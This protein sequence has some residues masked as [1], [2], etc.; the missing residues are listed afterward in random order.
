M[1]TEWRKTPSHQGGFVLDAG[2]HQIAGIRSLIGPDALST[3]IAYTSQIKPH[4]KPL[5]TVNAIFRTRGGATGSLSLSMGL[6]APGSSYTFSYEEGTVVL[7]DDLKKVTITKG[8]E[9][10]EREFDNST[11]GMFEEVQ[12]WGEGLVKGE[13]DPLQGTAEALADLEVMEGMFRSGDEGGREQRF[14]CQ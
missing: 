10:V 13:M 7:A 4:L 2:I 1:G 6:P 12:A 9:V 11:S 8:E 3:V 5:D 14:E